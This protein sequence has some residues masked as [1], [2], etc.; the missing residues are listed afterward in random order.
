MWSVIGVSE[1]VKRYMELIYTVGPL[2]GTFTV[3]Q[4]I[5][6]HKLLV[7]PVYLA[8]LALHSPVRAGGALGGPDHSRFSP[9]PAATA[10]LICHGM[11]GLLWVY[12]D[13]HFPDQSWQRP[14]TPLGFALGFVYPL[15]M[16]YTPM[17]CC[18]T[19][20]CP[21]TLQFAQGSEAWVLAL[22]LF[23]YNVGM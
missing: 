15:G 13:I 22:G 6:L 1:F 8:I 20:V 12:K 10:L 21:A 16:Y 19:D 18:V 14:M 4:C 11:Y 3:R 17:L 23:C 2:P 9:P 5:N 7:I